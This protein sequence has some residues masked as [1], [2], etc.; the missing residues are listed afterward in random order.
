[1]LTNDS[2]EDVESRATTEKLTVERTECGDNLQGT[3]I[4]PAGSYVQY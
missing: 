1:M 2:E 4:K 3:K